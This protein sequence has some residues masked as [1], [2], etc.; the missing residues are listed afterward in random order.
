[1]SRETPRF[2]LDTFE[3]GDPEWDHTDTV[4]TV[5]EYAIARGPI[6]D[7]PTE[8]QYDDELYYATDQKVLWGWDGTDGD[9]TIRGGTGSAE[10][11]LEAQ[12]TKRSVTKS[13]PRVNVTAYGAEGDGS[14][15]DTAAIQE[16][17]DNAKGGTLYFPPTGGDQYRITATI[18]M[19]GYLDVEGAT[20][21]EVLH[22]GAA[23]EPAFLWENK[24]RIRWAGPTIRFGGADQIGLAMHGMWFAHLD[25]P[26]FENEA[27]HPGIVC[28]DLQSSAEGT[29]DWGCYVIHLTSPAMF[30]NEG[31]AGIRTSQAS[32]D[33]MAVTHLNV[34]GGW[35][36]GSDVGM[37]LESVDVAH[38]EGTVIEHVDDCIRLTDS[39]G[40][41]VMLGET[42]IDDPNGYIVRDAGGNS[43][44]HISNHHTVRMGGAGITDFNGYSGY[45][46]DRLQLY[47]SGDPEKDY[48]VRLESE[49]T[50]Q[51]AFRLK[52]RDSSD[53]Q[54]LLHYGDLIGLT[55][56]GGSGDVV[57]GDDLNFDGNAES[58]GRTEADSSRPD[59]PERG[60][61][62]FDTNLG[63]PIWYD[64]SN[65]VDANGETV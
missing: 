1:M 40:I 33:P 54:E 29:T 25:S 53:W 41:N 39:N 2:N 52:V 5:D 38:I 27:G 31:A 24:K 37:D 14:T 9:W 46:W 45:D 26:S 47:P 57:L 30:I 28:L 60:Q 63:Q 64:G 16:A 49:Y 6:S 48:G 43:P 50:W 32:N 36:H 13:E 19:P 61:R 21:T 55:L 8:G 18:D 20:G 59:A 4:Q 44:P 11:P 17:A 42:R 10:Q 15:D 3:P 22:D 34:Y 7:R 12:Y 58:A 23:G 35:I 51:D 56:S 65:W 62:F